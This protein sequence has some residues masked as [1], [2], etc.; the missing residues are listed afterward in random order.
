M[1]W[2][3][4][5]RERQELAASPVTL[6]LF[7]PKKA[8]D[9]CFAAWAR[10]HGFKRR[11]LTANRLCDLGVQVV[12]LDKSN[13]SAS[14]YV[15]YGIKLDTE[16]KFVQEP[17]CDIRIP[18]E[19]PWGAQPAVEL[20]NGP[21]AEGVV[22]LLETHVAALLEQ[23]STRARLE[24]LRAQ[25]GLQAWLR[26]LAEQFDLVWAT[27]WG[28]RQ[29]AS[30]DSSWACR[31]YRCCRWASSRARALASSRPSSSTSGLAPSPGSTMSST[32][33][34]RHGR[35]PDALRRSWF[36]PDHRSGYNTTTSI[37]SAN[38][39]ISCQPA[40]ER[41]ALPK[42]RWLPPQ[43]CRL[44][45][46]SALCR[47]VGSRRRRGFSASA[48]AS[49]QHSGDAPRSDGRPVERTRES[50]RAASP[51]SVW[52]LIT[53]ADVVAEAP[54][55]NDGEACELSSRIAEGSRRKR[56]LNRKLRRSPG[57]AAARSAHVT[58][59]LTRDRGLRGRPDPRLPRPHRA[60][61]VGP[62]LELGRQGRRRARRV[63]RGTRPTVRRAPQVI[64]LSALTTGVVRMR[65]SS[66]PLY[67]ANARRR[68]RCYH[69]C[70]TE[71]SRRRRLA[72]RRSL[73]RARERNRVFRTQRGRVARVEIA[74]T[75]GSS[76]AS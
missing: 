55:T 4:R 3:R 59:P 10:R 19:G 40:D 29:I 62:G 46:N 31:R 27:T 75:Q 56:R 30:M 72:R 43:M 69:A 36:E 9:D 76:P 66:P 33:T 16:A 50:H 38:S 52:V 34:R 71:F 61:R 21:T 35:A 6:D 74:L 53:L 70:W 8:V 67:A 41:P 65:S 17:E 25:G 18:V 12:A 57:G 5:D 32:T 7:A 73:A 24:Q 15:R 11:K 68:R 13:F 42:I 44:S 28:K 23:T 63:V 60:R 26:A 58:G 22:E 14:Y 48:T 39:R 54:R 47:A 1:R 37:D 64:A 20:E 2:R 45:T 51:P 49:K